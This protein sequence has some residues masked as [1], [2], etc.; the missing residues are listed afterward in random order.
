[1]S[2]GFPSYL[3]LK[4]GMIQHLGSV[5]TNYNDFMHTPAAFGML[6]DNTAK[7]GKYDLSIQIE[8][9]G[10]SSKLTALNRERGD[11]ES[12]L[13]TSSWSHKSSTS[14]KKT[15]TNSTGMEVVVQTPTSVDQNVALGSKTTGT[16]IGIRPY[17][18]KTSATIPENG[19]GFVISAHGDEVDNIRNMKI[20]DNVSVSF[21]MDTNWKNANFMLATGPLLVQ[22]GKVAMTIDPNSPRV[23]ERTARTAVATDSTGKRVFFVTVDSGV[24]GVSAGMTLTEFANHLVN[25]GAH[26]AINLDG[27]GSTAMVTRKYGD[28]YP[29][30]VNR[31]SAGSERS[32][33]AILEAVSTAP[34]SNPAFV[35]ASQ[36]EQG[37]IAIGAS[38]GFK[39]T[40]AIDQYYNVLQIDQTK[41]TLDSVTNGV[42]VIEN[43]QFV[44]TKA[45]AGT[46]NA[47]YDNAP[48]SIPV[49]VTDKIDDIIITPT[50]IRIGT[51]E[52][53][54]VD[55]KGIIK[56]G[57]V[58]FNPDA[59]KLSV[60]STV[61]SINGKTFTAGNSEASGALTAT[62]GQL[63][64]TIPVIVS[65]KPFVLG[66]FES[67]NGLQATTARATASLAVE[68]KIQPVHMDNS[69]RLN[70]DFTAH[71][72]GVS[73]AYMTWTS[74]FKIAAKPKKI[75]MWVY[76]DGKN[77]WLR[78]SLAD[79]SGKEVIIDFTKEGG[80]NWTGWK[81][82]EATVPQTAPAPLTLNR[83]YVAET[84]SAKKDKGYLLFDKLQAVYSDKQHIE[85][86][87]VPS[88]SAREVAT[89]K[90][91][92]VTFTQPM[93][94]EFFTNQYIYVEDVFGVRQPVTVSKTSDPRKV[95]ITAPT[96]GY[97]TG[98]EYRL[99][100]T[101]FA[102]NNRGV[103]MVKDNITEFKVK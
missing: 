66:S 26:N 80:L 65:D 33:S 41:L 17:G 31:P 55:A 76:G 64:K 35:K 36:S 19:R 102:Q 30:L 38:V 11:Q 15:L 45:G 100:V 32:V 63:Q 86:A 42:G 27:G 82:V 51:G 48:V 46:V 1:M 20:G 73:A 91:F 77:H 90:K 83:I 58:I 29:T 9:A 52:K 70:Y 14:Y 59:V 2:S 98:K 95:E 75:G 39:V 6:A 3:L 56:S 10:K 72:E 89:N 103:Q 101:H 67:T 93:K 94:P 22:N 81:Y 47:T 68:N 50:E 87:F 8:H 34:H 96:N 74:G 97:A 62:F 18:Q 5:S 16:V 54:F 99:V 28:V 43:N 7:I 40:S 12:I 88:A 21:N 24:S 79:A 23:K 13:Y 49:T 44:G 71:K 78:G 84:N 53:I 4:D 57:E 37:T 61:G 92:T 85:Q 25:I 60:P 69:V